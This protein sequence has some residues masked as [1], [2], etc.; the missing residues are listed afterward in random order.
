MISV[1]EAREFAEIC[2]H[3]WNSHE[4]DKIL[5]EHATEISSLEKMKTFTEHCH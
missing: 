5:E 2:I 3:A 1:L 4:I